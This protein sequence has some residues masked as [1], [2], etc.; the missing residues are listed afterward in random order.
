MGAVVLRCGHSQ[1]VFETHKVNFRSAM[2]QQSGQDLPVAI[3]RSVWFTSTASSEGQDAEAVGAVLHLDRKGKLVP[4]ANEDGVELT[5]LPV[6]QRR[7]IANVAMVLGGANDLAMLVLCDALPR[8]LHHVSGFPTVLIVRADAESK[9][10]AAFG[11]RRI[12][13]LI[14]LPSGFV[15]MTTDANPATSI[16]ARAVLLGRV[17]PGTDNVFMDS[18]GGCTESPILFVNEDVRQL[19]I[20][21]WQDWKPSP[22]R[23]IMIELERDEATELSSTADLRGYPAK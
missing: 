11:W 6:V 22:D 4:A 1:N 20:R 12:V 19:T 23:E 16:C 9:V 13:N 18:L 3:Q 8:Y 14:E 17:V 2:R 21:A 5:K 15:S 10:A 7:P